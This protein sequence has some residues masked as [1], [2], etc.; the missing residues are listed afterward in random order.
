MHTLNGNSMNIEIKSPPSALE[1]SDDSTTGMA[2]VAPSDAA[3]V[4]NLEL[5]LNQM[6]DRW[7]RSEAE[8]A[9]VRARARRDVDEARQFAVQKFATDV[10]EAAENLHRGVASLPPRSLHETEM[11]SR[12]RDGFSG[13]ERSFVG[14]L[15]RNGIKRQDPTG[16]A[17]DAD[18]HQAMDEQPTASLP[19]GTVLQAWSSAWT[20]NGRLLRPAMVVVATAPHSHPTQSAPG[21]HP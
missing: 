16:C 5:E 18:L 10:V 6:R 13:I 1:V 15:E 3:Q 8:I 21:D 17:F 7:M 4:A 2:V 12:L 14:L 20:L 19:P 11:I 9:N